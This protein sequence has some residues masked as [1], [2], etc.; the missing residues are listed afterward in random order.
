M[1]KIVNIEYGLNVLS[2][3]NGKDLIDF[4]YLHRKKMFTYKTDLQYYKEKSNSSENIIKAYSKGV[5]YP[6]YCNIDTF[7]FVVKSKKSRHINNLGIFSFLDLLNFDV[8]LK[9]RD[10]ILNEFKEVLILHQSVNMDLLTD[11]DKLSLKD[12]LN[13]YNWN[14]KIKNNHRHTYRNNLNKYNEL[15][16]KCGFN[17]HTILYEILSKKLDE[18]LLNDFEN[19]TLS[20]P[21]MYKQKLINKEVSNIENYTFS[22]IYKG[23]MC[24]IARKRICPITGISLD[25]ENTSAKYIQTKTLKYLYQN[26]YEVYEQ[27]KYN[28]IRNNIS[29]PKFEQSEIKHLAKQIRNRYYNPRMNYINVLKIAPNQLSL[30]IQ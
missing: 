7:R 5:Q 24:T 19:Y 21:Q 18:L 14:E 20:H 10:K 15:L 26:S 27:I 2:P 22:H 6:M 25:N 28:L 13:A 1:M 11:K 9:I 17:I 12:C 3:I 30:T 16:T 29:K 4:L 23:G 8:Y